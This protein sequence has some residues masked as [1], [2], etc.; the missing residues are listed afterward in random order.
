[1]ALHPFQGSD[2]IRLSATVTCIEFDHSTD[3]E[4]QIYPELGQKDL[5]LPVK[6]RHFNTVIIGRRARILSLAYSGI[7]PDIFESLFFRASGDT[8]TL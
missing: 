4:S 2:I 8:S 6:L 7:Q 5:D 1:M 3:S